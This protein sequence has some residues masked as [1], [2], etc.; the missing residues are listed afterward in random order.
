[1]DRSGPDPG[2]PV[3]SLRVLVA[4]GDELLRARL[5]SALW[6]HGHAVYAEAADAK[7]ALD[8]AATAGPDVCVVDTELPGT[9]V[10]AAAELARLFPEVAVVMLG[11]PESDVDLFGALAAGAC[12]YLPKELPASRL[13]AALRRAAKGEAVLPPRLVA[14]LIREFR[15]RER[16]RTSPALRSLTVRE[17]EVLE[18]LSQGLTTREIAARLFVERVTVRTHVAAILR[19]LGVPNRHAA[20]R[21]LLEGEDALRNLNAADG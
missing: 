5:R 18:L 13:P 19:K 14:R 10:G 2:S 8:A 6:R 3:E 21:L 16:R 4:S 7:S 12:G 1:M 9:G 11:D 17:L 20:I 15:E